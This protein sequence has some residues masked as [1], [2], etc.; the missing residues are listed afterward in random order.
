MRALDP[1]DFNILAVVQRD[2]RASMAQIGE[3]I[4]LSAS[5]VTRRLERLEGDRVILGYAAL[6]NLKAVGLKMT[7]FVTVTLTKQTEEIIDQFEKAIVAL[8]EVAEVHLMAGSTDYLLRVIS[9]DLEAYEKFLKRRLTRLRG[10]AH[11]QTAF[12]LSSLKAIPSVPMTHLSESTATQRRV[13][14]TT[15]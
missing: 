13:V 10:V 7:A 3:V 12:S 8:P 6:L 5:A 1:L 15:K 14:P 11:V 2:G 4:G 9:T